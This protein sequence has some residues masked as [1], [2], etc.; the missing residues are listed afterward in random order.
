MDVRAWAEQRLKEKG[1]RVTHPRMAVLSYLA[2]A[3]HH[4]T[5][6]EVGAAVNRDVPTAARAS[7]YNVLHSLRDA[8]IVGELVF[9]D[10]VA[11]YDVNVGRHHHFVCTVCGGVEDVPWEAV[12][13][14]P[15]RR[16]PAGHT[17]ESG[18]VTLRGRWPGGG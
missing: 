7:V 18:S 16:L 5:A 13:P 14:F 12:P 6:E 4:P 10:A 17:V 9:E 8:G 3:T 11:R 15:K 1:L 2:G